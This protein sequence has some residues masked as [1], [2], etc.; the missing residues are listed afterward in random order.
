MFTKQRLGIGL[1]LNAMA[2]AMLGLSG[3]FGNSAAAIEFPGPDPGTASARLADGRLI[4]E[5]A[6]LA[7]T[8]STAEGEFRLIQVEDRIA[9]QTLAPKA[10]ETFRVLL[11]DG[12]RIEA[13]Q[14]RLTGEPKLTRLEPEQK[15]LQ[16]SAQP[17]GWRATLQLTS[18]D[19][20]LDVRWNATLRDQ[21]N[22]VRTELTLVP[23]QSPANLSGAVVL[24]AG[25]LKA[26]VAGT[27]SGSPVIAGNL[28]FACEHPL[29]ENQVEDDRIECLSRYRSGPDALEEWTRSAALGVTPPGQLRRAFLYYVERERARP[30]RLFLHYNSWWDIAWPGRQM[31]EAQC[32]DVVRHFGREMF[33]RR[34]VALDSFVFDDGWD[35]PKTLWQF[36]DGFPRGFAPHQ[37][38]AEKQDSAVGV[39]LSPWGG[40]GQAKANRLAYGK[41][42]GFETNSRGFSLAGPTYYA[43]YADA[44]K[45]MIARY[46]TNYF[47][48]DGIGEGLGLPGAT[49]EFADDVE[50][51]LRLT[52]ELREQRPDV[53]LSITTGT[54]PSPYWLWYGDSVWRN[55][56]DLGFHGAGS[57]RQ[58]S[59]TYRDM[60]VRRMIVDRAP[61]YP[62]N[63]LMIVSVCQ[64]QLGTAAKMVDDVD[65]LPDE[66]RMA[67][68]GGTQLL[69]LYVTPSRMTDEGWDVLA[70]CARWSRKNADVLIDVHW[71]GGDPGEAEPYGYAAWSPGKGI[72]VLRNPADTP[73]SI[74]LKLASAFELPNRPGTFRIT[75]PWSEED[76]SIPKRLAARQ[77]HEFQL[78]PLEILLIEA[79]PEE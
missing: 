70:E 37:A 12:S 8:W 62:L 44:C 69:E 67:F 35:D 31:D 46:G 72:L 56:H 54:W 48:F 14:F 40:Y 4:L 38:A 66:I 71:V 65:D 28:F 74:E 58:Q 23:K 64:A 51:L 60:F 33:E 50:A 6:V 42:Q 16:P 5:N 53:Y 1:W 9:H 30:Y 25:P 55:G 34:G 22:Y 78:N 15:A 24:E 59:I 13:S 19:S 57:M 47:K 10:S 17:A 76:R 27:V 68:A 41:T 61:L 45:Q 3:W 7:A 29:A 75:T 73:Q 49:N 43:R 52:R 20:H 18:L 21:S 39:W 77:A 63:S 26:R 32:L 79:M 2:V 36:H 11:A